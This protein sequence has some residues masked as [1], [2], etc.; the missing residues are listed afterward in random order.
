[1][2]SSQPIFSSQRSVFESGR[3]IA[4]AEVEYL[5]SDSIANHSWRARILDPDGTQIGSAI[6]IHE[7]AMPRLG[8]PTDVLFY[9]VDVA[10]EA[11][12]LD[13]NDP[14]NEGFAPELLQWVREH[15]DAL[16]VLGEALRPSQE[17]PGLET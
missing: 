4:T 13:D 2:S 6:P 3:V 15:R 1:M 12:T 8:N 5:G 16:E 14:M 11:S 10:L 17:P 9:F 7:G